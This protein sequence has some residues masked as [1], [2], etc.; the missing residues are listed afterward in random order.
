MKNYW[1]LQT[2]S[3]EIDLNYI[4]KGLLM[5]EYWRASSKWDLPFLA[6]TVH[7]LCWSLSSY[8][9]ASL[10]ISLTLL[11]CHCASRHHG[12]EHFEIRHVWFASAQWCHHLRF[13]RHAFLFIDNKHKVLSVCRWWQE[14]DSRTLGRSR[15]PAKQGRAELSADHVTLRHAAT[16]CSVHIVTNNPPQNN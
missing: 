2:I 7:S 4:A 10:S 9:T 6:L 16:A 11:S 13:L 8:N 5:Q 12:A 3:L 1:K 15:E 14:G